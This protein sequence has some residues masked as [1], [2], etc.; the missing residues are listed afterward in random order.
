MKKLVLFGLALWLT[1]AGASGVSAQDEGM[2]YVLTVDG[3]ITA[4]V[5][6]YVERGIRLAEENDADAVV[7]RLNTPGGNVSTTI[8]IMTSFEN[9]E[10][11]VLVYIWPRGGMAASAGALIMLAAHGAAMAPRTTVGAA[12][13]V[14]APGTTLSDEEIEKAINVMVEHTSLF[15]ERRG[16]AVVEWAERV[17]RESVTAS[18]DEALELGAIDLIA[19]GLDDLLTQFDGRTLRLGDGSEVTLITAGAAVEDVSMSLIEQL[20]QVLID[21]NIAF[22]LLTVGMQAVLIEIS[23]PGGWVAGFVG[24]LCLGMAAYSFGVL[25]FNWLG[26]LLIVVAFVLFVLDIKAPTHGALTAAGIGTF[27]GGGLILFNTQIGSP[28]GQLSIPLV[29][30]VALLTA[31]LF[32]FVVA[33]ALRA[34]KPRPVTGKEGLIGRTGVVKT[35]IDPLGTVLVAGERWRARAVDGQPLDTGQQVVVC[36]VEGFEL[37]VEKQ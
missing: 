9:A 17:I 12:H 18:A 29:V 1:L 10:V 4:A 27:I 37:T 26:L 20:L 7:I 19:D 15:A 16:M 33:K 30:A 23:A 2:V 32:A 22:I 28:Y 14:A 8:R 34:Q 11:P 13:P 36:A 35:R 24:V 25:P 31:L 6:D 5:G 21:P 3:P